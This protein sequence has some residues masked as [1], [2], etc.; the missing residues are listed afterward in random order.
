MKPPST[1]PEA[2]ICLPGE[3]T[4]ELWKHSSGGWQIAQTAPAGQDG[5]PAFFKTAGVFGYPVSAAFA[6]PVRAATGD[7]D[8]LPDI[9]DFQLEKQGLKPE[10]PVG[11]LI[12][13]RT[14]E[15]EESRT[16]VLASVLNSQMADDLP[17][18]TVSV[19]EWGG[20]VLV[21]TMSGTDRDAFE[22]SLLEK[23]GR[24]TS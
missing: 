12:D 2:G 1:N 11:N 22:A 10:T 15:R 18:E 4:W 17:R 13:W 7:A 21:R 8:M 19:P 5:G 6:V 23:D 3:Q 24:M 14:V 9:I 16:L 20:E